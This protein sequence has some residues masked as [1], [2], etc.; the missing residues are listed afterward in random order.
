MTEEI[1]VVFSLSSIW[2]FVLTVI[3]S[4]GGAAVVV[5]L[6]VKFT[7][8][9]IAE[10]LQSKYQLKLDKE[11][12]KYKAELDKSKDT[13]KTNLDT[14]HYISVKRFDAEFEIYQQ[15]S[16]AFFD[17]VR[18]CN[19]MIPAGFTYIPAEKEDQ[20]KAD[21]E[22]YKAALISTVAAQNCLHSIASF[23]PE[24]FYFGYREILK[25][26]NMQ[27][28]AYMCRHNK[29]DLRRQEEKEQFQADDY[30]RTS[31]IN[32][33]FETLNGKVREYLNSLDVIQ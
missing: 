17:A 4:M 7:A 15:L 13:H 11:L 25:L 23:I 21:A 20:L 1:N 5:G 24:E 19:V 9:K 26:M 8:N 10:S 6:A 27:L 28:N 2:S 22:H 12:E 32:E 18:D 16:K 33:K 31:E 14:K 30:Q 3:A 29:F